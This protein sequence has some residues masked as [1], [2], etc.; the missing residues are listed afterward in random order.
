MTAGFTNQLASQILLYL[1]QMI[2]P[3]TSVWRGNQSINKGYG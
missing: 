3:D 1:S 2:H